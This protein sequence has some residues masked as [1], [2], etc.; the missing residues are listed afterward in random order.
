MP[1]RKKKSRDVSIEI[2]VLCKFWQEDHVWNGVAE[3]LPVA[4]FGR[5]FEE[6][7]DNMRDAVLTHLDALQQLD[8]LVDTMKL[9]RK[10]SRERSLS[11]LDLPLNQTFMRMS[12]TLYDNRLLALV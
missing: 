2:P 12:A 9:L 1:L 10:R 3:D 4:I 7:Q 6:A 11:E 8:Q 5:T